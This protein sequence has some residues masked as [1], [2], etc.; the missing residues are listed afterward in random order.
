MTFVKYIKLTTTYSGISYEQSTILYEIATNNSGCT[1]EK[2]LKLAH[3]LG[4]LIVDR[5]NLDEYLYHE[6]LCYYFIEKPNLQEKLKTSVIFD[7]LNN[8]V[9]NVFSFWKQNTN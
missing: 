6:C 1:K 5:W 3:Y 4:G 8:K 7:Y 9:D 2:K